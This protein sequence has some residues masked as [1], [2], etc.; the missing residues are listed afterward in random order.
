MLTGCSGSRFKPGMQLTKRWSV[1]AIVVVA[2]C[3]IGLVVTMPLGAQVASGS[4]SA[5][6]G[7]VRTPAGAPVA[8]ASVTLI[9]AGAPQERLSAVTGADGQFALLA[10]TPGQYIVTVQLPGRPPT[11]PSPINVTTAMIAFTVSDQN[12]LTITAEPQASPPVN[13]NANPSGTNATGATG[14]EKLSS[15]SVSELPLNGRD[16]STL[17]LL[18]AGTMTDV[19]GATNF[20]QQFAINGQRAV[21]AVFAMD[22]ADVSDPEMGGSTFTNFNVDAIQELQSSSGWMPA[23]IGRGAAGFTNIVTRSG[24]SGF[25]GSF[26]EFLRNSDL[27]ARNY[28]DHPS[29]A[30]PGRIPPF[31]RNEFGFTNGGPIVLPNVY[32]GRDR[33]F[34]FVQYQGFRQVLGTTQVLAVPTAAERAGQDV[35][36]YPDGSMDTLEIAGS[37]NSPGVNPAIAAILARYPLP[38]DPT[39]AYGA[40]TYAA[41][42]NVVTNADQ[43]SVR[44]D[45][46]LGEKGQLFGRFNYDNLTGP[47]TNPDQTLLDPSFGVTY[48]DRQRN[49]VVTYIRTVSPRFLWSASVSF[50]RTTPSFVTPNHSDPAF[51]FNDGLYEAYNS[52]AGSV[53]SAFGNLFQGQLNFA[54]TSSR[55]AVKWGVEARVNRDTTYFGISPNGEYDFGGGTVYSPV[56]IP[57]ASGQHNIQPGQPLPDTLSSLLLGYPYSYTIAVAPPYASNGAHIGP[58]AINRNDVNAYVE[59]A[60]K[61]SPQWTLDYGLRYEVY[62]PISER[63]DRTSSFLNSFPAAGVGQEYLINPQPTYQTNWNGWGPRLQVNWNAPWGL[64]AHAGGAITVIPPNI[65]QDN[66]LTGSTPYVVYPRVNAA[67]NGQIS[68]GFQ[69]TPDELPQVFNTAGV[70]VLASGDPKKVPANTVMDVNRY[71]QDLAALAPSHR[72]SLLSL[73]GVDR[74]FG[75]GFLQSWTLGVERV[76]AGLTADV[77]YVGTSAFRLPGMSYPN[78]YPGADSQFARFTNFDSSGAVTGGFGFESIMTDTAHSSYNALQTSLSGSVGHGGPLLQAGYTWG[79]SLDDVSGILG[80][81]GSTGAVTLFSPQ[82]PFDTPAERGP[83]SFDVTHAFTL[84]AAQDLHL[85]HV[86][87][88]SDRTQ[89]LSKGWELLSISTLTSG[90]PFTVYS[91]IQQTGAGTIGA[92]RP[93]QIGTPDLS[94]AGGSTR[95]RDDY[96]GLGANNASFFSIP[97][98]LAGGTG[99]NSGRF[100][101]LGRNTF[102]GPAYYDF[103]FALIKTTPIGRRESGLERADLQFRGEFFNLFNI[104]NMGQ[105]ANIIK[106][107]GFGMISKTAGTS[108][109]IQFSLKVIY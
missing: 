109:Q 11:A 64:H 30:D 19:N 86:G 54:W 12:K 69:I 77:A 100:G 97:I 55:H 87:V 73:S 89:L 44:I 4:G 104:V 91:G 59:D 53:M 6:T 68:Y 63:A 67:Q 76:F 24:K 31:R 90:S 108:R 32:D 93:D 15:R 74:R 107:T 58:A 5:L 40:R 52:A 37:P 61:I 20:T 25:H 96:F 51:K 17:L 33:T 60:W 3:V 9:G 98:G 7:V 57:S 16:F 92:D 99:P 8:G 26:F 78:A 79:K 36:T 10:L 47:T 75:N 34:Y 95:P 48:V 56:F 50:T 18:A 39:G 14:G 21:E 103:D 22:G 94:T 41:P 105:P 42:S 66:L 1:R 35:V 38:N 88:Q 28:F 84:S 85:E 49:G 102:R 70:N 27:D 101:T 62:T 29:I 81:T 82:D 43:F 80:G 106:G 65:W 83:S 45:Q 23:D 46:K 71:Q 13:P 2:G 72:L